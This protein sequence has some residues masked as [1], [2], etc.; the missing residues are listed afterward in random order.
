MVGNG[1]KGEVE[2]DQAVGRPS[3]HLRAAEPVV[4]GMTAAEE[5]HA[6]GA[7]TR[8][9]LLQE[10][11]QGRKAGAGADQ[12]RR[13]GRV[14]GQGEGRVGTADITEHLIARPQARHIARREAAMLAQPR[15]GGRLRRAD[16]QVAYLGRDQR[17]RRDRVEARRDRGGQ[18]D[19]LIQRQLGRRMGV[20]QVEQR[21]A[22]GRDFLFIRAVQRLQLRPCVGASRAYGG[23]R[24]AG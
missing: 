1:G 23:Q 7:P 8:R 18:L 2:I 4:I 11:A 3:L 14:G 15:P 24:A 19:Q 22:L 20:E 21:Q 16:Q 17:R 6:L 12:D 10:T 5:Q 9:L 13:R